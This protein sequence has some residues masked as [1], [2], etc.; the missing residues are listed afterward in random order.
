MVFF[1]YLDKILFYYDNILHSNNIITAELL[2]KKG[3][4]FE[5]SNYFIFF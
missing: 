1:F 2:D 5:K 3:A 4:L